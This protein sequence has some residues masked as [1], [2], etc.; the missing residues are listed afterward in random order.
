MKISLFELINKKGN[1]RK[2]K[3]FLNLNTLRILRKLNIL[4][5]HKPKINFVT[6]RANWSIKWDGLYIKKYI[7]QRS[8][9]SLLDI[10]NIPLINSDPKVIHF[11]SQYM[12]V[13]WKNLLPKRNKYIVSFFHGKYED[14]IEAR[15][16]I[17]AFIDSKDDLFK[18]I[19]ASTLI[20]N[21]LKK[22][23][24]P[25]S[26]LTLIPIGVD[27]N[28]FSIPSISDKKRIRK[29]L[30]L[31]ENEVIIGS[32]QKD[33]VGW[34]DGNIPKYIKGPD[35]FI[36]SVDLISKDIPITIL[37]TG[38]ARG[39]IKNELKK[40]KI[41]FKH[42][43]LKSYKE[44]VDFYH[45]LDLYIISS[46]EEG[47]PK[48]IVEAMASGVPIVSTNVGMAND[49]IVDRKNGGLVKNF[50]PNYIAK[51]SIEI[52]NHPCRDNLIKQ[53]RLDVMKADWKVVGEMHW[54]NAYYPALKDLN[55][56]NLF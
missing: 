20:C 19:T 3:N 10:S 17:D 26:K 47:G 39:Y 35:L 1:L 5:I 40:R 15:K 32:F 7:N 41:K 43:Y 29:K 12:W 4:K 46:R 42:F 37:L 31:Q 50:E 49:F 45:A 25:E 52:I 28:L 51:K 24:I 2:L 53:A 30:G 18:V 14:G 56:K 38:P 34:S 8:K 21:R 6:E 13:D 54:Q 9:D 33:G 44:I 22:W 23:G 11:G 48:A 16:H 55:Q 27:T 36:E